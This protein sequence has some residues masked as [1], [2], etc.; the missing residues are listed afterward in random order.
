MIVMFHMLGT[1]IIL[2]ITTAIGKSKERRIARFIYHSQNC[3]MA[4]KEET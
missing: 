2:V 1:V 4:N 3:G